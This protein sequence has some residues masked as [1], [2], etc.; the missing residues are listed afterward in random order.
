MKTRLKHTLTQLF[1][2][3][4]VV[5]TFGRPLRNMVAEADATPLES[6]ASSSMKTPLKHTLTQ[7]FHDAEVDATFGRPPRHYEKQ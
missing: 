7:L 4:E 2:E 5:A 3:A 1:H 6:P